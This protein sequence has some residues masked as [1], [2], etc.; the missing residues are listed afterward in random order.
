MVDTEITSD[1]TSSGKLSDFRA[2]WN[3][4]K[5]RR[6]WVNLTTVTDTSY[7]VTTTV[8]D[9]LFDI[10][11]TTTGAGLTLP[12]SD[13]TT[14]G[15]RIMYYVSDAT[16]TVT[17]TRDGSDTINGAGA[18]PTIAVNNGGVLTSLGNGDWW[19]HPQ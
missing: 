17:I 19:H 16:N 14:A 9:H 12:A 11:A 13:A 7:A 15:M 5:D 8:A 18:N 10:N 6:H 3:T 2:T 1:Q 4:S